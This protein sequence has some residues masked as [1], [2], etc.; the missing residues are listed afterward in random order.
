MPDE[1]GR[2]I[3]GSI[4]DYLEHLGYLRR[5]AAHTL[6]NYSRD[7]AQ[8][9]E[10][11][12]RAGLE[13]PEEITHRVLRR[14]IA[15][16][17]TRGYASS[18]VQRK[19]SA[20]KGFFRW[21]WREGRLDS[22]P[23]AVLSAPRRA[24]RLPVVLSVRELD[25]AEEG[26]KTMPAH[27][28]LRDA[29]VIELLYATGIRVSELSGLDLSDVDWQRREL[30]VFGKGSK[31]R[32]VPV[33][34]H[35]L[36]LLRRYMETE[37]SFLLAGA[38]ERQ[39][40][41]A[42]GEN[43]PIPAVRIPKNSRLPDGEPALFLNSRGQRLGDRGVRR[44]VEAFFK[45]AREEGKHVSPHTLRHTFAT[46]LLEGGADI[47]AVQELLGH[48][49]LATTQVYTHLSKSHLKEVY[50]RAHPRA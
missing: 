18:S 9:A 50:D 45:R 39:A 17:Q 11:A 43:T 33:Y 37:R 22:D 2:D 24:Q 32:L 35:A 36:L 10:F 47:R 6:T 30:R 31:E 16:L 46:H 20:V 1:A 5:H 3:Q 28:R 19:C 42:E 44:V 4:Q 29:A 48:A 40:R 25:A 49:D 38:V 12:E 7:L 34:P 26:Q 13:R 8:F 14:Y 41:E 21:L 27:N 15:Q 23:G